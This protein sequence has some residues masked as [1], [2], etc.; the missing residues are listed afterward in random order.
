MGCAKMRDLSRNKVHK[1]EQ[2]KPKRRKRVLPVAYPR[3][4]P[5]DWTWPERR[6]YSADTPIGALRNTVIS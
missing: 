6:R 3:P 4:C 1:S 2:C 5:S